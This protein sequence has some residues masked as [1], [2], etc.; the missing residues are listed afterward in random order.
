MNINLIHTELKGH[1]LYWS[2]KC[3]CLDYS[4]SKDLA[5]F[6]LSHDLLALVQS[7]S[8]KVKVKVDVTLNENS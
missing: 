6:Y 8:H 7:F 5:R 2:L 4:A 1:L 3:I